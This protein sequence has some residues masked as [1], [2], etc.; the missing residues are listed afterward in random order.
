[1]AI[2]IDDVIEEINNADDPNGRNQPLPTDS[3]I[4]KYERLSGL[5]FPD[6]YKK[7]LKTVSNAFVGF[8]SPLTLNEKMEEKYGDLLFSIREGRKVGVPE[9]WLPI[10]EDNGD[11]YCIVPDGRVLFWDHNGATDESWPNLATWAK[12]VWLEGN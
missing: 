1:M 7:F 6:E 4:D 2:T 10:C 5:S 3:L 8:M 11:Y 9:N 12:E